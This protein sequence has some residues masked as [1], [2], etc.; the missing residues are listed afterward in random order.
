MKVI[1]TVNGDI[2]PADLG[3]T[4]THEHLYCDQTLGRSEA[5]FPTLSTQMILRDADLVVRELEDFHAAGGRAIAEMT[6][7]GWGRDVAV[8]RDISRRSGIHVIAT[9]GFYVEDCIPDFAREASIEDLVYFLVKELV[10][11]ADGT[12]IRTGLL[13]SGVGRPV[14]EGLEKK[15]AVA[16]ARAQKLTGVAITTHT[17][18]SSRFEILGGNLGAQHLDIFE[19]EGVDPARVIVGHTDENADIRQFLALAKR[20]AM[21]QFDV[22]GKTHW[23]LDETRVILLAKLAEAGYEDRLL[24]STD[25]CRMT[26]I[27]ALGGPGYDHLLRSFL[28]KLR[29]AGF[30]EVLIHKML[31][32][33]PA[34]IL[35]VEAN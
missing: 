17:S 28:P 27:K 33:N 32:E 14:I 22:I 30:D 10:E 18:A 31:V 8:L 6:V 16:V 9:S 29:Q 19:A 25:R 13:K 26:E 23:L 3:V 12:Q 7:L 35:A 5:S 34:R 20:G 1:R 24:L 21:I 2:S 4:Q 15:C 11:G